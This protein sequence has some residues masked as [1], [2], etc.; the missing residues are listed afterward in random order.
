MINDAMSKTMYGEEHIPKKITF[1]YLSYTIDNLS[2]QIERKQGDK[3]KVSPF[4]LLINDGNYY[5]LACDEK[6][7]LK[8]YRVDRMKNV[9][10][11][12]EPREGEDV[13]KSIDLKT[14]TQRVFS[15][16]GGEAEHVTIRFINPLLDTMVERFGTNA[17]YNKVDDKHSSVTAKVEVSDQFFGWL[18]GFGKRVKL[19]SPEPVVDKFKAYL[20]KVTEMYD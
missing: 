12:G 1:K 16:F 13:F 6:G 20:N 14:Y 18:L 4:A 7:K 2:Q 5:L 8:T 17:V 11:S 9:S 19:I 3:Y 10:L 15:M